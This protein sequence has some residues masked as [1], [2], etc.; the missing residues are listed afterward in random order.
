MIITVN[1]WRAQ[2]ADAVRE[3]CRRTQTRAL[4]QLEMVGKM[5]R[6][7]W[8]TCTHVIFVAQP[9]VVVHSCVHTTTGV[10]SRVSICVEYIS[11]AVAG[12]TASWPLAGASAYLHEYLVGIFVQSIIFFF[13]FLYIRLTRRYILNYSTIFRPPV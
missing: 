1:S 12:V 7:R 11:T 13:T 4:D 3:W 5:V 2:I 9:A 6:Q 8:P 10:L